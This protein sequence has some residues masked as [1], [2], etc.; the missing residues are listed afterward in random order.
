[1][2]RNTCAY[3]VANTE[4]VE[5]AILLS[6]GR[7]LAWHCRRE[8]PITEVASISAGLLSIAQELH[9]FD[10]TAPEASMHFETKFGALNIRSVRPDT[11]L[12]LCLAGSYVTQ[13]I[14][15]IVH[16]ILNEAVEINQE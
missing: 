10:P 9:L 16:R 7:P 14:D 5:A 6:G 12:V 4:G 8:I 3:I 2:D 13:A 15:Q 11:Q 1:M